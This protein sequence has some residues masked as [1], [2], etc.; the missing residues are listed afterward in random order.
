MVALPEYDNMDA[1]ALSEAISNKELSINDV[2]DAAV[3]RMEQRNPQI[4]AVV[5]PMVDRWRRD[6][7]KLNPQS[8]LYGVPF[9]LKD[10]VAAYEG[11]PFS[12]GSRAL[13]DY[14]PEHNSE[15]VNRF[16]QAGLIHLGKTNTPEFG[17]MGVTEPELF[18]P[19]RNP[20]NTDHTPGGSSGGS[21]AAVAARIVP[22]ASAGDG[23]GSIR[24]PASCCGLFGLKPS[25]GRTPTG[26]DQGQ[27]WQ[28]AAVEHVL[29]RSVRDSAL[30]LD[31]TAGPDHGAHFP[32]EKPGQS[33][34]AMTKV[35]PRRLTIAFS[36]ENPTG[37][38][39]NPE[40]K[41]AVEKTAKLLESLGHIVEEATPE[42]D[43]TQLYQSYLAMNL[44]ETAAAIGHIEQ[45]LGRALKPGK[46]IE[47]MTALLVKLGETYSAK[48]F[49]QTLHAWNIYARTM[50]EFHKKYDL[51]LTPTMADLPAKVGELMPSSIEKIVLRGL[52]KLPIATL[53]K[54]SGIFEKLAFRQ[55][56][57]LPFTQLANLTGQP[58]MSVP[59]HWAD[60][61]LPV[62]VQFMAPMADEVTLFQLAAQLESELN[63]QAHKPAWLDS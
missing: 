27:L 45:Q 21:G 39:V 9:L 10:L 61:G 41:R 29:S 36:T 31:L 63:W 56:E 23:G 2:V 47:I 16:Q 4:N 15:M 30:M 46:D 42:Y 43:A 5:T 38:T 62:G 32:M 25:R 59:V 8:P 44:G 33:Y 48:E 28:G 51:Y 35:A 58:A 19:S 18:G 49:A 6:F 55:L 37:G 22:V 54:R 3:A 50:G 14:I 12:C 26:P 1:V 11:V 24:I 17:L 53:L 52:Y 60:N 34:L 57:K 7:E 13:A 40:C 20:W